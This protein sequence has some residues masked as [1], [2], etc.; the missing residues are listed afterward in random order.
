[1]GVNINEEDEVGAGSEMFESKYKF[2]CREVKAGE[3]SHA[4]IRA[5]AYHS[6]T[7]VLPRR[8][9]RG[10]ARTHPAVINGLACWFYRKHEEAIIRRTVVSF[11]VRERE[12][13]K[14]E[15]GREVF[16][17]MEFIQPLLIFIISIR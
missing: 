2:Y 7:S 11:C 1:M 15:G 9:R 10:F 6:S 13:R 4:C 5:I 8:D 12:R 16:Y 17:G 14:K 3:V